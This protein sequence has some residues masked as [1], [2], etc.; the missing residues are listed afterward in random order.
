MLREVGHRV[1]LDYCIV[2][3]SIVALR[4]PI[5]VRADAI[6]I[7]LDFELYE[8]REETALVFE[9]VNFEIVAHLAT[10]SFGSLR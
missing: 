7:P 9:G 10:S 1:V 4:T 6:V 5:L 3:A 2:R 8:H